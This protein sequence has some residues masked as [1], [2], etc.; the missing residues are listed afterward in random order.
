MF[1]ISSAN[2]SGTGELLDK[3]VS[4]FEVVEE[5]VDTQA[6]ELPKIAVVGRPNVGKSSLVNA[7]LGE[8]EISL[9]ILLEQLEILFTHTINYLIKNLFWWILQVFV[10]KQR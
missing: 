8:E 4:H 10:E 2:G 6:D 3:V 1:T 7:L 9:Q 5:E